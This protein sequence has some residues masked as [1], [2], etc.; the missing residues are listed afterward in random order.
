M[1]RAHSQ[2]LG[3]VVADPVSDLYG[4]DFLRSACPAQQHPKHLDVPWIRRPDWAHHSPSPYW[5]ERVNLLYGE[6]KVVG[7]P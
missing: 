7:R 1:E 2:N 3:V 5:R 4:Y 6:C